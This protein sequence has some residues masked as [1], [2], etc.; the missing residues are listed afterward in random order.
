METSMNRRS[1]FLPVILLAVISLMALLFAGCGSESSSR[2]SKS[3]PNPY[4]EFKDLYKTDPLN[5]KYAYYYTNEKL[6]N[7]FTKE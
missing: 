3:E 2:E 5:R 7:I 1:H 6:G 4:A